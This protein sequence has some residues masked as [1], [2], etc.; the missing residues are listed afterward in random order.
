MQLV[1]DAC[2]TVRCVYSETMDLSQLGRLKISRGS[3]VEPDAIG[4]WY[5]DLHPVNGPK[6]GPFSKRSEA[7]AA[8]TQWLC[9]HWLLPDAD[10]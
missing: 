5:A 1:I 8:E 9:D 6:L 4:D 7:L 2:G 3:H 10:S